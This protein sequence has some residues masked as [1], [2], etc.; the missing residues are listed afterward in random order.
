MSITAGIDVGSTYTKA[1][2]LDQDRQVLG[3][4]LRPTGFK[5]AEVSMRAH[6]APPS[7][8]RRIVPSRPTN[9]HTEPE[10][11]DPAGSSGPALASW[12]VHVTPPSA[13]C[14]RP[15]S[16]VTRHTAVS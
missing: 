4:D 16:S 2:I 15:P 3:R 7:T 13:E 10:G 5:L 11:A 8:V 12:R 6:E 1:I 9:Q 14:T